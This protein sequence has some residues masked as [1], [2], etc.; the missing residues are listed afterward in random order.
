MP[1][2]CIYDYGTTPATN[3]IYLW[4]AHVTNGPLTLLQE[5]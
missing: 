3:Y 4:C 1:Y 2:F 5:W